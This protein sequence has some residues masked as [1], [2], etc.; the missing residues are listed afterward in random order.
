MYMNP[1]WVHVPITDTTTKIVGT[2]IPVSS[3]ID[4]SEVNINSTNANAT[5]NTG[6]NTPENTA[7]V[8]V[9]VDRPGAEQYVKGYIKFYADMGVKMIR[10]DFMPWYETGFDHYLGQVGKA[11]GR[12]A[13]ETALRWMREAC[14]QYGVYFSLAMANMFNEG[15]LER[16]YAHMVRIDEDVD[17]GEWYKFSDKDRGH[18]YDVW[19]QWANAMDGFTYWSY[20]SGQNKIRLDGDFIRMNTYATDSERRTVASAHLIAGGPVGVTDQYNT[21][22][23][24]VWV[25]Q[26]PELLALNNDDFVGQPLAND[27]TNQSSQIW[28]GHMSNGDA[29]VGLFNRETTTQTRT[30]SLADIGLLGNVNARDLWQHADLGQMSSVS[31][32]LP[33]HG[34]M[35][36]RLSNAPSNCRLQTITFSPIADW[37]YNN[38]PPK[39]SAIASSGLPVQYEVAYGP[40]M[41]N[42]NQV[43]PTGQPGMVYVV[44]MQAGNIATCAA[45]PQVQ[46]FNASGPHQNNMF[47][48]GSFT[49]WTPIRMKLE[50]GN[51]VADNVSLPAGHNEF[52]FANTNNF[53]GTDWG[54][55]Q[56]LSTTAMDTAG[57]KPNSVLD[58]PEAGF[59]KVS[60]DDV[61]LQYVWQQ[62]DPGQNNGQ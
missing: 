21:I 49:S 30:L 47:L 14:D 33:P 10:V 32:Q 13:Y 12:Q 2:N 31:V 61:T 34:A 19:S 22:G 39:V 62:E 17:Y 38:P 35:V 29:I 20:I 51:W 15:E 25:Y 6:G 24:D 1:L 50:G 44:A 16:K 11:H 57:G 58:A 48:F 59:Y 60:F 4:P 55:G 45:I 46:S 26:N 40:A 9:Q 53:S 41:V 5:T 3:L 27:P 28:T 8:W 42:A 37:T 36:L 52:K 7:F 18:R 56:G 54:N 23:N 43:Q